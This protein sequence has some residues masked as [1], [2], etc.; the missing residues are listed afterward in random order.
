M[1]QC[2]ISQS[3]LTQIE[4]DAAVVALHRHEDRIQVHAESS[5]VPDELR[6]DLE[7]LFAAV[8]AGTGLGD[9]TVVPSPAP[10]TAGVVIGVGLGGPRPDLAESEVLRRAAGSAARAGRSYGSLA[11]ALPATDESQ[12]AAV[13]EGAVLGGYSFDAFRTSTAKPTK[14]TTVTVLAAAGGPAEADRAAAR[15]SAVTFARDLVN[16]PPGD[17]RPSGFAEQVKSAGEA[18]GLAVSV[19]DADQLRADAS[20]GILAVGQGSDDPPRLIKLSYEPAGATAH[21]ALVGK[22]I[23]FDSGGL[24]LKPP[25]SMETMK[26]DMSGAAAVAA[27]MIAI[28]AEGLPIRVTGWLAVAEN[29]PSGSA[30]RPGDVISMYGGK[31]VEVLNT[32]AEGRLVMGDALVRAAAE[33]PDAL[34]DIATLTGAQMVALGTTTA[35]VM[36]NHA[37]LRDAIC[38]VGRE[39]GES[40]WPMPLPPELRPALDSPI[41]DIANVGDRNGGMLTAG[42]F[43]QEFVPENLPWGHLDIAGPAFSSASATGY[44]PKGGT[45]FGVMTL[46]A[47]ARALGEGSLRL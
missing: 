23:T 28:A 13:V 41:A 31:T 38:A 15:A 37:G 11:L 4:A 6:Q 18:A 22:G 47:V 24:S 8:G 21:L 33:E 40:L 30:Q 42:L 29:M 36:G 32:D 5:A 10:L 39:A 16:T 17:L 34:L 3:S 2:A 9:T 14:T 25:K 35:G 1:V 26:C 44:T 12:A 7:Q 45:G 43:L 19:I 27:A 20:G 46:V